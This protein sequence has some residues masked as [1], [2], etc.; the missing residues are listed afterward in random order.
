VSVVY[1]EL[2]EFVAVGSGCKGFIETV[3]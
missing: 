3:E 1:Q 2:A